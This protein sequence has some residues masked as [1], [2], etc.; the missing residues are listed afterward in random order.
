MIDEVVNT[1]NEGSEDTRIIRSS[2]VIEQN[3]LMLVF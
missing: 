3:D 1:N 2:K